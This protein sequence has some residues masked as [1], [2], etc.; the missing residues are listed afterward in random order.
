MALIE[1]MAMGLPLVGAR[2]GGISEIVTADTGLLYACGDT[3][4]LRAA[5]EQLLSDKTLRR[6]MGAAGRRRAE[7]RFSAAVMTRRIERIYEACAAARRR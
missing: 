5:L 1:A 2:V 6:R 3:N 7:E 4:A